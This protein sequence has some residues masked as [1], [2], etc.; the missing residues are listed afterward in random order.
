MSARAPENTTI[1]MRS[2]GSVFV[3][4]RERAGCRLHSAEPHESDETATLS[5]SRRG[6]LCLLNLFQNPPSRYPRC[7]V[8]RQHS[9]AQLRTNQH[10]MT[11]KHLPD[12]PHSTLGPYSAFPSKYGSVL[13][14]WA[15]C[16][17]HS[18]SQSITQPH[19]REA[20]TSECPSIF[21][22]ICGSA[23]PSQVSC[24]TDSVAWCPMD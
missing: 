10:F 3:S 8:H 20:L 16:I 19:K 4:L 23:P 2:V 21:P 5:R 18:I 1:V 13:Q 12:H 7:R 24:Y 14:R 15:Q 17:R 6:L 11:P 22:K 9:P